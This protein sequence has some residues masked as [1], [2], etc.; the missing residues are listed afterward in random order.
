MSDYVRQQIPAVAQFDARELA[1]KFTIDVVSS[2]IYGIDSK[3]FTDGKCEIRDVGGEILKPSAKFLAYFTALTIF[4]FLKK[5]WKIPFVNKRIETYFTTL[6]NDAIA[7]RRK[8]SGERNDFL[9]YLL[10]L[11]RKKNLTELDMA[12]HTVSFFLDGFETSSSVI[13]HV[14]YLLAMHKD[15]QRQ[16][17]DAINETIERDGGITFDNL[18]D[19]EY[20]DHVFNG[21]WD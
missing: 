1:A 16:L 10:E 12:A 15:A 19:I 9:N 7:L 17:R 2:C 11:Q 4:P 6:M 14:F 13:S 18:Q 21:W 5:F 20:L 3:A 8:M